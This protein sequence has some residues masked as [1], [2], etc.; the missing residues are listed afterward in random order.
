MESNETCSILETRTKVAVTASQLLAKRQ[1][2]LATTNCSLL[3][4]NGYPITYK[5]S[6]VLIS[7]CCRFEL[8][9]MFLL[10]ALCDFM[11]ISH[12]RKKYFKII[13]YYSKILKQRDKKF[14]VF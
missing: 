10:L 11:S 8:F 5:L 13:L 4:E 6:H 1:I 9:H 2:T 3:L 7:H 14:S 12:R